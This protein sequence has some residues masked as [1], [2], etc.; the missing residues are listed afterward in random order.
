MDPDEPPSLY[1][2]GNGHFD[3]NPTDGEEFH[4]AVPVPIDIGSMPVR[5][6]FVSSRDAD[7]ASRGWDFVNTL[8][9]HYVGGET[10]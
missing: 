10:T 1:M 3:R 9:I 4:A 6:E 5:G 7:A 8:W 2:F